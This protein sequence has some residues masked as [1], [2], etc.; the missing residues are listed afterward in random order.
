MPD[1]ETIVAPA[2]PAGEAALAVVRLSGPA[3][4]RIAAEALG[5]ASPTPR[6]ATLATYR[7]RAGVVVDQVV[8]TFYA[9]GASYT[10]EPCLE[11]SAHGNPLIVQKLLADLLSRGC[12]M[13][14]PGE[15]TRT[16]FRNG[17]MDLSQAEAV[18]DLIH[19]RSER[20]LA[21]ARRQLEGSVGQRIQALTDRLVGV[22][23]AVEAYID[24]PEE[25]LP[26]EDVA[27]P[28]QELK[29]LDGEIGRLIAT[30]EY[31][32]LLHEGVR[33]LLVGPPN[34]G[35]SSLLNALSGEERVLVSPEPGTTRDYVEERVMFGPWLVRLIDTAGLREDASEVEALGV[36]K[37]R[38]WLNRADFLLVVVDGSEAPPAWPEV[39][40]AHFQ[41]G[42]TLIVANKGDLPPDAGLSM[43]H[44]EHP[45]LTVSATT[46]EGLEALR[47]AVVAA[48]DRDV[49]PADGD[50]VLVSARH[51]AALREAREAMAAAR[52]K[53]TGDGVPELMASDLRAA[54]DA[55]GQVV[56]RVDNEE[57]LDQLFA[58]FCIG[59]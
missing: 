59:K 13:A 55:L 11:I 33:V 39:V 21:A 24:F 41:P 2:T 53:L 1:G 51:A 19:A 50:A 34:A 56:G 5:L 23:A 47:E 28:A 32:T 37:T 42:R 7:D 22:I 54:L 18:A 30:S 10:G 17:C 27:G 26:P 12:R 57:M 15:F 36:A 43:F 35:K 52:A 8:A 25:D 14:D 48:L 3:C 46:G 44:V 29:A 31:R 40:T 20:A 58:A 16:A 9:E 45:H 49:V 38:E 4:P 6:H